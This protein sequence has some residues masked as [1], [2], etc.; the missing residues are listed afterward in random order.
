[1]TQGIKTSP[2]LCNVCGG[3]NA[4]PLWTAIDRLHG[5]EG[6]FQYV[7]CADC[8]MVYMNPQIAP[9]CISQFYPDDYAPHQ[10]GSTSTSKNV[11]KPD[12]PGMILDSLNHQ[13]RVLDVGCG[14]GEF[15]DRVRQFCHCRSMGSIPLEMPSSVQKN[16]MALMCSRGKLRRLLLKKNP[17]T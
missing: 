11:H 17:L 1:M 7:Q 10:A 3:D 8:G 14:N 6:Q 15:L 5:F 4:R 13:S 9:E 16:G 2:A 12:L